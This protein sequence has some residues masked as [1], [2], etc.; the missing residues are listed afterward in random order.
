MKKFVYLKDGFN[1]VDLFEDKGDDLVPIQSD[2]IKRLIAGCSIEEMKHKLATI[3]EEDEVEVTIDYVR[4]ED[5]GYD[6]RNEL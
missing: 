2:A 1:L 3:F 4:G 5:D 6:E